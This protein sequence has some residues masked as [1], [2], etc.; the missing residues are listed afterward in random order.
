MQ[1]PA[2][3]HKRRLVLERADGFC[4]R[5]EEECDYLEVHHKHY[6]TF[7]K[8]K[9]ADLMAV[10]EKCHPILDQEREEENERLRWVKRVTVW[11]N[12]VEGNRWPSR[13]TWEQAVTRFRRWLN[14]KG[15]R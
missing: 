14:R 2:W 10:C 8:E 1:S 15:K 4:E 6:R 5:C 7:K 3:K 9:L 12:K 11:M 13:F